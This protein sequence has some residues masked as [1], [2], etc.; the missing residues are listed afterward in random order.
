MKYIYNFLRRL[1]PYSIRASLRYIK[2]LEIDY[3]HF[4][5]TL[6][7]KCVDRKGEPIPWYTYPAIDYIKR[8]DFSHRTIFEYGSGNSTLFWGKRASK[9]ISVEDN[10][11]WFQE[12]A[13]KASPNILIKLITKKLEYVNEIMNYP[14]KF[15]VI[16]IDGE[17]SRFQCAQKAMLKLNN[18]GM[19]ILDNSENYFKTANTLRES[20]LIQIDMTGFGPIQGNTWTTSFFLNRDF[21][22]YPIGIDQPSP[23]IGGYMPNIDERKRVEG[24]D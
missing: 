4:Y 11:K 14:Y 13:K 19:I 7:R 2:I 8:V 20:G 3:N 23:V 6:K 16:I 10:P 21:I 1:L 17:H 12:I 5:T 24:I 15:D 18:G 22:F 9:V